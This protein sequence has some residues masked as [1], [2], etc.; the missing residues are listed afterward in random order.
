MSSLPS[1]MGGT[2]PGGHLPRFLSGSSV[3]EQLMH[4]EAKDYG[5]VH[6][7]GIGDH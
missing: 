2:S 3:F 6:N 5:S 7:H 1:C 4:G